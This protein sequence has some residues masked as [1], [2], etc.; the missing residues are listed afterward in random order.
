MT[1][2]GDQLRREH[3]IAANGGATYFLSDHLT[4]G[5]E[6]FARTVFEA[7]NKDGVKGDLALQHA[8]I[9]AGPVL[10]Y[11]AQGWWLA[12]TV[13]PQLYGTSVDSPSA[14]LNLD[15]FER[16]QARLLLGFHL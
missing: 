8:A 9:S 11:A 4:L 7:P 10:G 1:M 2:L 16:V 5:V 3:K 15:E 13:A 12:M 14:A 6:A